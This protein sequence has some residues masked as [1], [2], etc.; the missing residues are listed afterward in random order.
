L[1]QRRSGVRLADKPDNRLLYLRT[2]FCE[3]ALARQ[4]SVVSI[5]SGVVGTCSAPPSSPALEPVR[6]SRG[7]MSNQPGITDKMV[8]A[9]M[10]AIAETSR[11]EGFEEP[12]SAV[13]L[14]TARDALLFT[15]A[16]LAETDPD[17]GTAKQ[18]RGY[19][20]RFARDLVKVIVGLRAQFDRTGE[21][22]WGNASNIE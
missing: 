8:A 4:K 7:P 21:R 9:I 20:E 1:S 22:P 15:I 19:G 2:A 10:N 16:V 12:E 11:V 3:W 18:I 13:N 6:G 5:F 14:Q 17:L